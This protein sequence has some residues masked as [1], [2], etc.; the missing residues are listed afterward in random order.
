MNS[1]KPRTSILLVKKR[2]FLG[3][4]V[5]VA[6]IFFILAGARFSTL[7][8]IEERTRLSKILEL[9]TQIVFNLQDVNIAEDPVGN[10]IGQP[11]I[12]PDESLLA[13]GAQAMVACDVPLCSTMGKEILLRGGNAADAAITVAL[14]IGSV[15]LH[16]SGI[17]G[18]GYIVSSKGD[19]SISI[20]AR[21][22]APS[23][24]HKN[25]YYKSPNLA[26]FGGL[27]VAIPGELAGLYELF[28]QH[29]SGNLTWHQL[30]EPV[31]ELNRKGWTAE[32]IW[33]YGVH[34]MHELVLNKVPSLRET[35][36]FIYKDGCRLLVEVG[37][38]IRRPNYADTLEMIAKNGSHAIFYDPEGPFA[39]RL[40]KLASATGG[41]LEA[42]DFGKYKVKVS[43][44]LSYK[45]EANN[46]EYELFTA[47]GVSSGL[48]LIAGLGFYSTL[49]KRLPLA[50][51]D[52][53][54]QQHR[55]VEA[56]KW[57]SSARSHLG[58]ANETY[59]N[60]V[61]DKFS[62]ADWANSI[63]DEKKYSDNKTFEWQ[64]YGPLFEVAG[65]HGTSH[66][67]IVDENGDSVS[68]TTTV[69][70]LFGSMVYDDKTGIILNDEMDDFSLPHH[71][72]AF[73]LT[74]SV[75]N[76][77]KP[78]HRP[79]SLMSPT[80]I[81][82]NGKT[83]LLIGAAGGSRIVTAILQAIIRNIFH[84]MPLLDVVAYSRVHHQLIPSYIMVEN[85]TVYNDEFSFDVEKGLKNLQHD[86]F[87]SG[88]LTAMNGI[89]YSDGEW[90]GVSDYWRK[91]GR[92]D[93]Y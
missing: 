43:P 18:G 4:V 60:E 37:D 73:N 59:W 84:E 55:L 13:K 65:K 80:I 49:N 8:L 82:K 1:E 19:D 32:L 53:L 34:K 72:N 44:A 56:M 16:S 92:A 58:D 69:N 68:M 47:A 51:D 48:A 3:Y 90:H 76:F 31:I 6:V 88:A 63:I 20:D 67:S 15:N 71:S 85:T 66:F 12:H 46:E 93:G 40:A 36:D 75:L 83:D 70:L 7:S 57:T 89:K 61:K 26:M 11:T 38:H 10:R 24:A 23:K 29:G 30:F 86:F 64:H 78:L 14:C 39:P 27:A 79:L 17:G 52:F 41:I 9:Q 25:M 45:F 77:V 54:L 74:P 28:T 33:V 22:M 81:K 62:S 87:E 2:R 91:H 50:E 35:W 21:E 42:Q 5:C